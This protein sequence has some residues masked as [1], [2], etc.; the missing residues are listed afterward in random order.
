MVILHLNNVR[1]RGIAACR[2]DCEMFIFKTLY[3]E[4]LPNA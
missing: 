1:E 2:F 3:Y 4:T